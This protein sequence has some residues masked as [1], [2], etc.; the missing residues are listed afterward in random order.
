MV[1]ALAAYELELER[2]NREIGTL[3]ASAG[4]D[5]EKRTRLAFR[6]YHRASL[7]GIDSGFAAAE[8]AIDHAIAEFGPQEDLCLLKANL[9]FRFHRL[10][11]V[12]RDLEMAPL[13]LG[14]F[15]GR[16]LVA[17]LDFQQGRYDQARAGYEN[18]IQENCTW[19]TLARL[20]F[21][22]GKMG[23]DDGADHLYIQAENDLTAKEMR[24]FAWLELQRGVRDLA[25]GR[26]DG[27][28]AHYLRANAAY[29]GWWHVDEHIAEL[30]AAE[31][32]FEEAI[33]LFERVI[34]RAPKPELQQALGELHVFIGKPHD[35]EPWFESALAAYLESVR[36]GDVH[37]FHHLADFYADV[38][39]DGSEAVK[40]ARQ[41]VELRENFATQSAMAW[42]WYRN[43]QLE[44]AMRW[45]DRALSSGVQEAHLFS[46][47]ATIFEAAGRGS[48]STGFRHA[49]AA[50]NPSYRNFHIHR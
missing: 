3:E 18:A 50:I 48:E 44:E 14:R 33:A 19:D 41:D 40:W 46:Q 21:L 1:I 2:T 32:R 8:R 12:K 42:A 11:S 39:E 6:L 13:L 43:G 47:A 49:A 25:R 20:A 27:A 17:D 10:A 37:Y 30:T 23:D 15:E 45:V 16:S 22:K 38:R 28:C 5:L 4:G 7:A 24:S 9:D 36:R 34:E 35:A 26:Y 31:G 29:S